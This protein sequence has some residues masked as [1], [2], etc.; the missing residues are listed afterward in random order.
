[1]K[2]S[3]NDIN[4]IFFLDENQRIKTIDPNPVENALLTSPAMP[5][6][7]IQHLG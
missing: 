3:Q 1:M 6:N 4:L 7:S 5:N 2:Q